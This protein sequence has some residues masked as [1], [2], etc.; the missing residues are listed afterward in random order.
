MDINADIPI[1]A[2]SAV[3]TALNPDQ[4]ASTVFMFSSPDGT[5]TGASQATT[6]NPTATATSAAQSGNGLA[7]FSSTTLLLLGAIVLGGIY[8]WKRHA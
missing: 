7:G 8:L 1:S 3:S 2:S 5:V 6:S 4:D